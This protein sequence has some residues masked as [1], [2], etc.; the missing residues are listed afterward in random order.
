MKVLFINGSPHKKGTTYR[1]LCEVEKILK[2]E[3]IDSLWYNVPA[4]TPA[5]MACNYCGNGEGCIKKD[6]VNEVYPLLDEVDGL[7]VGTPVH[8]AGP[9]GSLLSFLDR[10]FYSYPNKMS[11]NMKAAA[12]VACSRRAGNITANDV[13]MK[14]FSISGMNVITSTYWNDPHGFSGEDAE[15]DEEGMQTMRNLGRNMAYYLKMR[16]L[17]KENGLKQP[18][19]EKEVYTH[20]IR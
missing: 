1:A 6:Q 4:D 5:C 11:L 13:I 7:I 18:K 17:A 8:Y 9:S 15:K 10:L 19:I 14:F 3:G 2:E 20:F 16:K 12:T